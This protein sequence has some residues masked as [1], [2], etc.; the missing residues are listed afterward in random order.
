MVK[1]LPANAGDL[2]DMDFIT[3]L[4]RSS[5]QTQPCPPPAGPYP[6][7]WCQER[8]FH[9]CRVGTV[10]VCRPPCGS[11]FSLSGEG[12]GPGLA[13]AVPRRW[14]VSGLQ[15]GWTG[16]V[17]PVPGPAA[18]DCLLAGGAGA[19]PPRLARHCP[20]LRACAAV[21]QPRRPHTPCLPWEE[22]C[23]LPLCTFFK[24]L[25]LGLQIFVTKNIYI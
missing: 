20:Q 2:G 10:A 24:N 16:G 6:A 23:S 18:P 8:G 22:V 11:A 13:C 14:V 12:S 15:W 5:G 19:G 9:T 4:G 1:N 21:T 17:S 3:G 7:I 25:Y